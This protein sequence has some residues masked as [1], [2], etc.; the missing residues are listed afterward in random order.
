MKKA[1]IGVVSGSCIILLCLHQSDLSWPEKTYLRHYNWYVFKFSTD[2]KSIIERGIPVEYKESDE[3]IWIFRSSSPIETNNLFTIGLK[4]RTLKTG[5]IPTIYFNLDFKKLNKPIHFTF[6]GKKYLLTF[7]GKQD[8]KE[9]K[10]I[11]EG[12]YD[13]KG[14]RFRDGGY[15]IRDFQ[16]ALSINNHI[17]TLVKLPLYKYDGFY[18]VWIAD[19]DKDGLPDMISDPIQSG[20]SMLPTSIFL[21]SKAGK[22]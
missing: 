6:N 17:E 12:A 10:K 9:E 18:N 4:N 15:A 20:L 21:S 16:L 2:G 14:K 19:I 1:I 13:N 8:I 3:N 11:W 5:Y 7:S 22:T